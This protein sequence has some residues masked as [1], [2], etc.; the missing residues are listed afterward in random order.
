MD[1]GEWNKDSA[2]L[3]HAKLQDATAPPKVGA[4]VELAA[5]HIRAVNENHER[6]SQH[7]E[8][9]QLAQLELERTMEGLKIRGHGTGSFR[10]KS[11]E[12]QLLRTAVDLKH[13]HKEA[14]G[15]FRPLSD[16][17][18]LEYWTS[19]PWKIGVKR[20]RYAFPPP[21]LLSTLVSLYFD[22]TNVYLPFLHR[23]TFE[24][25]LADNL[26]FRDEKFGAN[27][28]TVCA[29]ASRFSDDPRVFD[30]AKP[31]SCGWKYFSQISSE[32]EDLYVV[33]TLYDIQRFCLAIEFLESATEHGSWTLIGTG[34]RMAQ[35]IGAHRRQPGPHTV[36]AE[37]LRRAFWV[38]VSYDRTVSLGLGRPCALQYWDF[39]IQ[40]PTECDDEYWEHTDP[41]QAFCQPAGKPSQ[42]AFF[43][44]YIRV[45]NILAHVLHLLYSSGKVK[46]LYGREDPAWEEP[47]VAEIDSALNKWVDSIP[48][49]L[50]WDPRRADPLFFKQSAIL[51]SAY[52]HVQMTAHRP[53][54]P[55]YNPRPT[56]LPSLA[57]CTNAARSV[58]HVVEVW[59]ER[60][61]DIPA[62]VLLPVLTTASV[63]LLLNVWS[64]KRTGLAPHMNSAIAEVHKCMEAIRLL[65]SRWQMA[66]AYWDIL[67]ALA[68]VGQVPLPSST[69]A[70]SAAPLGDTTVVNHRKRA[71]AEH[72]DVRAASALE[73]P[74]A[75][76]VDALSLPVG[77]E[78]APF[79]WS[80]ALEQQHESLPMYGAD[81]GRLPVF[82]APQITRFAA[83]APRGHAISEYAWLGETVENASGGMGAGSV[84]G[85]IDNDTMSLWMNAPIGLGT[86]DWGAYFD[87]MNHQS[88]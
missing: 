11:S 18:R 3:R 31:L 5:M 22:N 4:A 21:D 82:A 64:G 8:E 59:R 77:F 29:I 83:W 41:E 27:V 70:D 62:V 72:E 71:H 16:F 44:S 49:H 12:A 45:N 30:A 40:L 17:R 86:T 35:E 87:V 38:L 79:L 66:G 37:L 9:D 25:A 52:Y 43:N 39:D 33:P 50:Q 58:S 81:L 46:D 88:N 47:I 2:I 1:V 28:L 56:T 54:I 14:D 65:E 19:T 51:Y 6:D 76:S 63:I 68:N 48:E 55:Q 7:H 61:K 13:K 69:P 10:G 23:P 57:I 15:G 24:H 80:G 53:F 85:G 20:P 73:T 67:N 84:P 78:D 75:V 34:L 60:V 32:P 26:H 74:A 36:E 42:V